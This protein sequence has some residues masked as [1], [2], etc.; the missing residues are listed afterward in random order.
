MRKWQNKHF[1]SVTSSLS[2]TLRDKTMISSE[3][4]QEVLKKLDIIMEPCLN[5]GFKSNTT[6]N[7]HCPK[8]YLY[9]S[10]IHEIVMVIMTFRNEASRDV[11]QSY[12]FFTGMF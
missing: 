5:C 6:D 1:C 9:L 2:T 8:V 10:F 11:G 7:E 12:S 4:R 3:I